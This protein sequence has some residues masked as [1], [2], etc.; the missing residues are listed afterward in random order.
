MR[1]LKLL[2]FI[3]SL[4]VIAACSK[5]PKTFESARIETFTV[6]NRDEY[7]QASKIL[8]ADYMFVVDVSASMGF[9]SGN[10]SDPTASKREEFMAG[11]VDF[12]DSLKG[13]PVNNNKGVNYKV[14]F[15]NGNVHAGRVSSLSGRGFYKGIVLDWL[16]SNSQQNYLINQLQDIGA[17]LNENTNLMLEAA[18]QVMSVEKDNFIRPGSQLI[19]LFVSDTDDESPNYISGGTSTSDYATKLIRHKGTASN[20]PAFVSAR[21]IV[22]GMNSGCNPAADFGETTGRRLAETAQ[23]IE[24]RGRAISGA[25]SVSASAVSHCILRA[26]SQFPALLD[27]LARDVSK[28]TNIFQLQATNVDVNSIEVYKNGSRLGNDEWV[29]LSGTNAVK[30]NVTPEAET[31]IVL[32]YNPY[33][34][35]K[36]RPD[37]STLQVQVGGTISPYS[38]TNGWSYNPTKNRIEFNGNPLADGTVVKVSY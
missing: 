4:W 31:R 7:Q 13:Q 33:F 9:N 23:I 21:A 16:M 17:T 25:S 2:G 27:L 20:I 8:Q 35:L 30:L 26:S 28:P 29:Y 11:L 24:N 37:L 36:G 32:R 10:T 3:L 5:D 19:Y 6:D 22:A 15:I 14:G 34:V 12:V 1:E 38:T 18:D